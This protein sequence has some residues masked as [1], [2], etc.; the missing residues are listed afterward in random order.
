MLEAFQTASRTDDRTVFICY[1]IK[2]WGLP[3][4]GHR[5]NHG[6]QVYYAATRLFHDADDLFLSP[7]QDCI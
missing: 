5:D 2:G 1:T 4:Q 3:I 6:K 7:S